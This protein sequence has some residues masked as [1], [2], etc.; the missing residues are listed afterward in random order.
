MKSPPRALMVA[1]LYS[2]L[3]TVSLSALEVKSY[4]LGHQFVTEGNIDP[5]PWHE[6]S[7]ATMLDFDT[8][9]QWALR[10]LDGK[11]PVSAGFWENFREF[12]H[13]SPD[14]MLLRMTLRMPKPFGTLKTD[15]RFQID[16]G[17]VNEGIL[18]FTLS[19]QMVG[20]LKAVLLMTISEST[21]RNQEKRLR[22]RIIFVFTPIIETILKGKDFDDHM[23]IVT[24]ILAGNLEA[25]CATP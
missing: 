16:R 21:R 15:A 22:F 20:V 12:I 5:A 8:Y 9:N 19:S 25:R 4:W 11:D 2:L 23:R 14:T 6:R 18:R 1:L 17:K 3:V 24:G 10:G 13:D 7:M